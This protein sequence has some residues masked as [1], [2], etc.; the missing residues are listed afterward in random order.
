MATGTYIGPATPSLLEHLRASKGPA[1]ASGLVV[2][3]EEPRVKQVAD[4]ECNN[5]LTLSAFIGGTSRVCPN[6]ANVH[7]YIHVYLAYC[8]RC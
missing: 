5:A 7:I 2:D 6:A 4:Y 1:Y 8:C 3:G